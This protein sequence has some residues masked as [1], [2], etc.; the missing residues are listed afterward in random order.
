MVTPVVLKWLKSILKVWN[1]FRAKRLDLYRPLPSLER[2]V[3]Y[4]RYRVGWHSSCK[5][6]EYDL[7]KCWGGIQTLWYVSCMASMLSSNNGEYLQ[8]ENHQGVKGYTSLQY[9]EI[10]WPHTILDRVELTQLVD[11]RITLLWLELFHSHYLLYNVAMTFVSITLQCKLFA[12]D[13]VME[14]IQM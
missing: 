14:H 13:I 11:H 5:R 3:S 12:V 2:T 10:I 8:I 7:C 6:Y 9:C 4:N 1:S